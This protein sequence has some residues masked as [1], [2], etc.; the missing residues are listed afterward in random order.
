MPTTKR[1]HVAKE[2]E[3]IGGDRRA[4]RRYDLRLD[5]RWKL[6]RRR[7]VL[8]NGVGATLDFSSGGLL[9]ETDRPLPTGLNVEISIAWPV[10]L[11]DVA[12]LQLVVTGRVVRS[13]GVRTAIRMVQ[14]EF[15]TIGMPVDSRNNAALNVR[16]AMPFLAKASG[17]SFR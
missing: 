4:D 16:S 11:R 13:E 15:R 5:L 17:L 14:H 9:F 6:I 3:T 7:R 2:V 10:L 12:P 8:D 1:D